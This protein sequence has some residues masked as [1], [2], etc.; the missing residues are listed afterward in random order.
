VSSSR[1]H[2]PS[3]RPNWRIVVRHLLPNSVGPILVALT[4]S[5]VAA[6]SPSRRSASS[7]SGRSPAAGST[8][9]GILVGAS[10]ENVLTGNWWMVRVPLRSCCWCWR[11]TIN[12]LGDGL[13][14]ATDPK[15]QRH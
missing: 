10:K 5:V 13:R 12:M 1:R 2:A 15:M 14:D 3:A 11:L 9:L 7:A 6:C 8:S 4:F